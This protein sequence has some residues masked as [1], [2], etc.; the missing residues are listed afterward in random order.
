MHSTVVRAASLF[1][2]RASGFCFVF[3]LHIS[4]CN[5]WGASHKRWWCFD[6]VYCSILWARE[7]FSFALFDF[8]GHVNNVWQ[9]NNSTHTVRTQRATIIIIQWALLNGLGRFYVFSLCCYRVFCDASQFVVF[10]RG[11]ASSVRIHMMGYRKT[12]QNN[13]DWAWQLCEWTMANILLKNH[14]LELSIYQK[15]H[16]HED[17]ERES[18]MHT[19]SGRT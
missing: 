17:W 3:G 16:E 1:S 9:S 15:W 11:F 13:I 6:W 7:W 4:R 14:L 8:C 5:R 18:E 19:W 2:N 12:V 10:F